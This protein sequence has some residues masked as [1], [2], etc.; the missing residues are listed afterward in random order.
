M[1]VCSEEVNK[2]R[3]HEERLGGSVGL[4]SMLKEGL[5]APQGMRTLKRKQMKK[6]EENEL[7]LID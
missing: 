2:R 5:N 3:W 1:Y 7:D 6:K 4:G